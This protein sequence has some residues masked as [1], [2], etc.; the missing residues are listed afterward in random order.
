MLIRFS[1]LGSESLGQLAGNIK[2]LPIGAALNNRRKERVFCNG[3]IF[4]K[5][6]T[7]HRSRIQRLLQLA[8]W[9]WFNLNSYAPFSSG[10]AGEFNK[11]SKAD[12]DL[13]IKRVCMRQ[14]FVKV[15]E[16][17]SMFISFQAN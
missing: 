16:E 8:I 13:A 1:N 2:W 4:D 15:A 6:Q 17:N 5:P 3:R 7:G 12:S 9:E 11:C 14:A 10:D